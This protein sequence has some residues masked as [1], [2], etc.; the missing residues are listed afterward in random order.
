MTTQTVRVVIVD[1]QE[2]VRAGLRALLG[3]EQDIHI[4]GAA[5]DGEEALRL[6]GEL[7]PDV[8]VVDYGLPKMSG[9]E[10][11]E[12]LQKRFPG[13][14]V[15]ILTNFLDDE[16]VHSALRAGA[17]AYVYKDVD[18][19]DLKR[20]IREVADGHSVLDPKVAG[21]VMRWADTKTRRRRLR[22]G[23]PS[24]SPR[25]LEILRLVAQGAPNYEIATKLGVSPN[26][27]KS[28]MHRILSKLE[29][30]SRAEAVA[31][32]ARRGLL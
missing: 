32:A 22:N 31:V 25:E 20:A 2:I 27:I 24:L 10:L 17:Q 12:E 13:V 18:A 1:D 4:V 26:T 23:Q 19:R 21:K 28:F 30:H 5:P 8:A 14:S 6:V 16:I 3:R 7:H 29:C 15:I 11:T 9:V